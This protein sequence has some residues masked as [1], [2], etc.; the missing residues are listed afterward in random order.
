MEGNLLTREMSQSDFVN[1]VR[2]YISIR[3]IILIVL[4]GTGIGSLLLTEG[5]RGNFWADWHGLVIGL[6]YNTLFYF[7]AK[8]K[9][10]SRFYFQGLAILQI[11]SDIL[12]ATYGVYSD[13]GAESRTLVLYIIPIVISG[14]LFTRTVVYITAFLVCAVYNALVISDYLGIIQSQNRYTDLSG[15]LF[16]LFQTV[17]FY[18]SVFLIFSFISNYMARILRSD[19]E[20]IRKKTRD[21]ATAQKIAH[22]GSWEWDV[23]QNKVYLSDELMDI[24][25]IDPD[26]FEGTYQAII[27]HIDKRDRAMVNE[28]VN[29]SLTTGVPSEITFRINVKNGSVRYIAGRGAVIK[30]ESGRPVKMIGTNL[31]VTD[32]KVYQE[33]LSESR[34]ELEIFIRSLPVG[35]MLVSADK[36][37]VELV[38]PTA[39]DLLGANLAITNLRHPP[40]ALFKAFKEDGSDYPNEKNPIVLALTGRMATTNDL[41]IKD[42]GGNLFPLKI[43]AIPILDNDGHVTAIAAVMDDVSKEY[44]IERTKD[45]IISLVSH[46]LRTPASSV[47]AYL[48]LLLDEDAG[49]L[50]KDQKTFVERANS[51]NELGMR[52]IDDLLNIAR[53]EKGQFVLNS[54]KVDLVELVEDTAKFQSNVAEYKKVKLKLHLPD[55]P[56]NLMADTNKLTMVVSNL[57]DNAIKF[58]EE[59]G[60]VD[61][62]VRDGVGYIDLT[63]QDTGI[64]IPKRE[65]GMLFKKFQRLDNAREVDATGIGMGL[66]LVKAVVKLHKGKISVDST[67]GK[68]TKFTIELPK[69][70]TIN[71]PKKEAAVNSRS[72]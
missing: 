29:H 32:Q 51:S 38:N 42:E 10:Q 54:E 11:V 43:S 27:R 12:L 28:S 26:K 47:K 57:L 55:K 62:S 64:G 3:W 44:A 39:V 71:R 6:A 21:L 17:I 60:S 48:S 24:Y 14:L 34:E 13:G 8:F 37:T 25:Q 63:V 66:Y 61:V 52:Y 40:F 56:V 45:E 49:K 19:E 7:A 2:W 20:K 46:Q 58:T 72:K 59:G 67:L 69:T 22:L 16:Y 9:T 50:N 53:I 1:R 65:Q 35:A 33:A 18:N 41:F 36:L 4:S 23:L 5:S 68:G 31:D 15:D 30:D 70:N